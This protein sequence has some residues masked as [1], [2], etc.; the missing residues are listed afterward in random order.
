MPGEVHHRGEDRQGDDAGDDAG[1]DQ[2]AEGVDGG[3]FERIDLLGHL[4]RAKL[5]ADA[6]ADPS[7][8]QQA[9][10]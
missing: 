2:V 5:G 4:H 6:G 1:D 9:R 7:R 8:E 3:G 10:P